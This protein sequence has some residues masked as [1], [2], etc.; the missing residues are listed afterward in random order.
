MRARCTDGPYAGQTFTIPR[1][2]HDQIHWS[3]Y[4]YPPTSGRAVR[5]PVNPKEL[6]VGPLIWIIHGA[7]QHCYSLVRAGFYNFRLVY[8]DTF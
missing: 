3:V 5:F 7:D 4:R 2:V 6:P 8:R 1:T